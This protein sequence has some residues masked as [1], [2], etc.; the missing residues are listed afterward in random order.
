MYRC[1]DDTL[2][3]GSLWLWG[4]IMHV[5]GVGSTSVNVAASAA[6]SGFP[7][8]VSLVAGVVV[9]GVVGLF[10]YA[11]Y[12]IIRDATIGERLDSVVKRTF[13]AYDHSGNGVIELDAGRTRQEFIRFRSHD[14]TNDDSL[15]DDYW[16]TEDSSALLV[17]ADADRDARVTK[18]EL[19]QLLEQFDA[20]GNDRL[21]YREANALEQQHP[22]VEVGRSGTYPGWDYP[23]VPRTPLPTSGGDT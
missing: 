23:H 14:G 10:A 13:K 3:D 9:T 4:Q 12:Q 1:V 6:R 18:N 2:A 15:L 17:A 8:P 5:T 16:T 11:G 22:T 21:T 19:R 20:N 7:R